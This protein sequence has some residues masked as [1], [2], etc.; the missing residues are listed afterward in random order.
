MNLLVMGV[1]HHTAPADLLERVAVPPADL[2][3]LLRA[4]VQRPHIDAAVVLSTCNRLEVYAEVSGFHGAVAEIAAVLAGRTG[5]DIDT[6][7]GHVY[8]RYE[9]AAV[10]HVYRVGAGLDSMVV[11]EP[12]ILGQ[13][14]DAYALAVEHDAAGRT[15]HELMQRALR[16]G[17]RVRAETCIDTAG[18]DM[19]TAAL[20]LGLA[21]SGIVLSGAGGLVVGAGA[22]GAL[23]LATLRRGG[24]AE[25]LVTNRG[26][27]RACRLAA[28]HDATAIPMTSHVDVPDHIDVIVCATSSTTRVLT[29]VP[30]GRTSPLLILDLAVPR[31]VDPA[32]ARLPGVTLID[33]ESVR[34]ALAGTTGTDVA[35]AEVIV[36][37]EV[38]AFQTWLRGF[39]VAPTVAALR[40][41]ADELVGAELVALRR[42]RP[43][44]SDE[45][46]ADVARTVH[47]VVQ[48][49]LHQPTV[50]V[51]ELA[52]GPGGDRY[53]AL[54]RE[55]FDLD[56]A[57][58]VPVRVK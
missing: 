27:E 57:G 48:R 44:L 32:V 30:P 35:A 8:L 17:K 16:V 6:L 4:L 53:A 56:P 20:D 29:A 39:D 34:V 43:D 11:G 18:R 54:V 5:V 1:S 3:A 7:A 41:R 45:Q 42:R 52:A 31:D 49:L 19:I 12:Q 24:A 2:P 15:I 13:L 36:A 47:R 50:R 26:Y 38:A 22:M 9:D 58:P 10:R 28:N 14:R 25:L 23:A 55:L 37:E 46:R 33:V 21:R 40:A 51:R